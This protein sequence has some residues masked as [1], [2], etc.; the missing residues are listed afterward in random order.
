MGGRVVSDVRVQGGLPRVGSLRRGPGWAGRHF[1][2]GLQRAL[3]AGK[4]GGC[5]I[6][7]AGWDVA[8]EG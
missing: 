5:P 6:P 7:H 1:L 2:P 3:G 4:E 8:K